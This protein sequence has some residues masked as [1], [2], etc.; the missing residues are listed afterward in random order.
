MASPRSLQVQHFDLHPYNNINTTI[1]MIP[2]SRPVA[3]APV[4]DAAPLEAAGAVPDALLLA[5]VP[6]AAEGDGIDMGTVPPL[7]K[8]VPDGAGLAVESVD[9]TESGR[10]GLPRGM[11]DVTV[12]VRDGL[13]K[14]WVTTVVYPLGTEV[15]MEEAVP[16]NVPSELSCDG[17]GA[18]L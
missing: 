18:V 4:K 2:P 12:R 9:R 13:W 5:V 6:E 11:V 10:L 15:A 16:V 14:V 8:L 1:A 3:G 7:L 17:L